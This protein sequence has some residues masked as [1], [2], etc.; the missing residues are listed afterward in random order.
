MTLKV[1]LVVRTGQHRLQ[2]PVK[3]VSSGDSP[4][5]QMICSEDIRMLAV[6]GDHRF[7][8]IDHS[9]TCQ[10][11]VLRRQIAIYHRFAVIAV[12]RTQFSAKNPMQHVFQLIE[13]ETLMADRIGQPVK[14]VVVHQCTKISRRPGIGS[15]TLTYKKAGETAG[16]AQP[17]IPIREFLKSN[18][19]AVAPTMAQRPGGI[20][21]RMWVPSPVRSKIKPGPPIFGWVEVDGCLSPASA[22]PIRSRYA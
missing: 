10:R 20:F 22:R 18:I 6:A 7:E 8:D 4:A 3:M 5:Q 17:Y 13:V 9:F 15:I 14:T 1:R 19:K 21:A 2:P 11:A 16:P 12:S